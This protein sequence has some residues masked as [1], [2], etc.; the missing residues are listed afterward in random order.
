MKSIKLC[1]W[2]DVPNFGDVL[3]PVLLKRLKDIDAVWS[4]P[5]DSEMVGAGSYLEKF[6]GYKGIVWGTGK[7]FAK[8]KVNLADAK[9]LALRGEL[10]LKD[11]GC[12]PLALG[13]PV[14]LARFLALHPFDKEYEYGIIP[15]WNDKETEKNFEG[16]TYLRID[17]TA[18]VDDVIKNTSSCKKIISSSLHGLVLADALGIPRLWYP[19]RANPGNGF[20]FRD[21]QTVLGGK[22]KP[23]TWYE[24]DY[25]KV[26]E[27]CKN[28]L[29]VLDK[30]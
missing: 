16:R 26:N 1:W 22:I 30:I 24:A 28:L 15:H 9:V 21:Y 10:S 12:T 29:S 27:I 20:K 17:I 7:M 11:S 5:E 2:K 4:E 6:N 14:L 8:T 23:H 25:T 18:P 3:T 13:D 19:S